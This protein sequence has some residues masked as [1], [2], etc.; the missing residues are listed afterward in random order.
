M[1]ASCDEDRSY[2][3]LDDVSKRYRRL[4]GC[5]ARNRRL[6]AARALP[7]LLEA[8]PHAG[9]RGEVSPN[10][11]GGTNKREMKLVTLVEMSILALVPINKDINVS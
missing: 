7:P 10:S 9:V 4:L 8:G 2:R 1:T 11:F 5:L 6:A 3:Q